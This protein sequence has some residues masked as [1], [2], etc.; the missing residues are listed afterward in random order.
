MVSPEE[1]IIKA[2]GI[3]H[4][5][6]QRVRHAAQES[7]PLH[8]AEKDLW[9][10]SRQAMQAL[11]SA[12][13]ANKGAGDCGDTVTTDHGTA[14]PRK[15]LHT[16]VYRSVFGDLAIERMCYG[17]GK[18]E[19]APLD[20]ELALP[21]HCYSY[22]LQ[23]WTQGFSVDVPFQNAADKISQVLD[24]SQSVRS[25]ERL[26]QH[27][28]QSV[29]SFRQHE[30][31]PAPHTEASIVVATA[32]ATTLP[33]CRDKAAGERATRAPGKR[34]PAGQNA[35]KRLQAVCSAVYTVEPF[36]RAAE[37]VFDEVARRECQCARPRPKNKHVRSDLVGGKPAAFGWMAK[38]V[39]SRRGQEGAHEPVKPLVCVFDGDPA[40]W[41]HARQH[42]H[43]D[44]DPSVV[45]VLDL[46]HVLQRLWEVA[47]VFH[48]EGSDEAHEFVQRRL[49]MLLEGDAG[50]MVG[51]LRQ[52]ATKRGW[53]LGKRKPGRR[54][55]GEPPRP[56][57]C[58]RAKALR[59]AIEYFHAN[60]RYM[61]YDAYVRAGYPIGSGMAEGTCRHLIKDRMDRTGMRWT[62]AG[63][64]AMLDLRAVQL[65]GQWLGFW[66]YHVA[67][68]TARLY[69]HLRLPAA[70]ERP[71]A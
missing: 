54:R 55:A 11:L 13:V 12:Y 8:Q 45:G 27:A 40:L 9:D 26:N 68:E 66:D 23:R 48:P 20:A 1:Q 56:R 18:I 6:E 21:E 49:R 41:R 58:R 22:L 69:G 63:A 44:R 19:A 34:R 15:G 25:V 24:L 71:A 46:Y 62:V 10:M 53:P 28:A 51:G 4:R 7:V 36:V 31:P 43:L 67:Q 5:L 59:C 65:S 2:Q 57:E 29:E 64:Q 60:R 61:R 70:A 32:D 47:Y 14:L 16:R 38:Q 33:L 50:R 42:L 52:M 30:R 35:H 17:R 3:F 37:Q 39:A